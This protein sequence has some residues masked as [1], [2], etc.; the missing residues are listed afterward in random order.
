MQTDEEAQHRWESMNDAELNE[1]ISAHKASL[2]EI[3]DSL[4][5]LGV[6]PDLGSDQGLGRPAQRN[7]DA[8][9]S[10]EEN[11]TELR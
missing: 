8:E 2:R 7:D 9:G 10:G 4:S 11:G 6:A 1:E 5:A 3:N